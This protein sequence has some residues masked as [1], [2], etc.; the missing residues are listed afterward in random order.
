[1]NRRVKLHP[2]CTIEAWS[3]FINGG[4]GSGDGARIVR[5]KNR[6]VIG[7]ASGGGYVF[8]FL[9]SK[10]WKIYCHCIRLSEEAIIAMA[11]I[12]H[13]V[14]QSKVPTIGKAE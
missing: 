8:G 11:S 7:Y 14:N 4:V 9:H 6:R 5:L 3:D 13:Y 10:N 2:G 1:M 12:M